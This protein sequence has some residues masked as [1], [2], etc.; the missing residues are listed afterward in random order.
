M[1]L[2]QTRQL[3]QNLRVPCAEGRLIYPLQVH[4]F[5]CRGVNDTAGKARQRSPEDLHAATRERP[6]S[7]RLSA[8]GTDD[9]G[10]QFQA[11]K[12]S[13]ARALNNHLANSLKFRKTST[14]G[15]LLEDRRL[16][17]LGRRISGTPIE[18]VLVR[19][20]AGSR[21]QARVV[22]M[23]SKARRSFNFDGRVQNDPFFDFF[24]VA[25]TSH[26]EARHS[27]LYG[28]SRKVNAID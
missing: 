26:M 28:E 2:A 20:D 25:S 27:R 1:Q 9:E 23:P 14:D 10:T 11:R 16:G 24:A 17:I 6:E 19:Q 8:A 15:S 21:I 12:G 18:A 4:S 5:G 13:E 7:A 22:H 3:T